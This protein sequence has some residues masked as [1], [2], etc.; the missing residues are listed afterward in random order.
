MLSIMSFITCVVAS[1]FEATRPTHHLFG[2]A[3]TADFSGVYCLLWHGDRFARSSN[4][5]LLE[6]KNL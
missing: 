5:L 6:L 2:N 3:I 4:L 1:V